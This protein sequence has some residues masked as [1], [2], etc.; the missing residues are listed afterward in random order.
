MSTSE[1]YIGTVVNNADVAGTIRRY[2]PCIHSKPHG[3]GKTELFYQNPD[4]KQEADTGQV[5]DF[6]GTITPG[7]RNRVVSMPA[8]G[9]QIGTSIN[10]NIQAAGSGFRVN[11]L[12]VENAYGNPNAEFT[13]EQ[14]SNSSEMDS[15][16]VEQRD[17]LIEA[18]HSGEPQGLDYNARPDLNRVGAPGATPHAASNNA[19]PGSGFKKISELEKSS[20]GGEVYKTLD[21]TFMLTGP[22]DSN[23]G[24]AEL[25]G[26]SEESQ[27]DSLPAT[28]PPQNETDNAGE[29]SEEEEERLALEQD[30]E[31]TF[32]PSDTDRSGLLTGSNKEKEESP[33]ATTTVTD[34]YK[35]AYPERTYAFLDGKLKTELQEMYEQDK[36]KIGEIKGS[37][38]NGSITSTDLKNALR[39][40]K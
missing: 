28:T 31:E 23:A 30:P 39:T 19:L 24:K 17:A 10:S 26:G 1:K 2:G 40:D 9:A 29:T 8:D 3:E 35:A 25:Q 16:V 22:A 20:E 4:Y 38:S 37:G 13:D 32:S 34:A 18:K 12:G 33:P 15:D 11:P 27:G 21:R 7:Q 36:E 14:I 6:A 5:K